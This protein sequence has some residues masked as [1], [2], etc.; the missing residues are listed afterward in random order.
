MKNLQLEYPYKGSNIT[1]YQDNFFRIN[2]IDSKLIYCDCGANNPVVSV[3]IPTYNAK[4][5]KDAIS[6]ALNQI[7]APLYEIVVVDN[8]SSNEYTD[9]L[10]EFV[11]K[12]KS[13]KIK[14]YQNPQNIGMTGNW[15]KCIELACTDYI[16]FLHSDDMLPPNALHDLWDFHLKIESN[17]CILGYRSVINSSGVEIEKSNVRKRFMGIKPAKAYKFNKYNLFH[18]DMDNG[19]GAL[20]NRDVLLKSGGFYEDYYPNIDGACILHYY[21]NAPIYRLNC[22]TRI[23]RFAVGESKKIGKIYPACGYFA[24][25]QIVDKFFGGNQFLKYLIKLNTESG[26]NNY[27][28]YSEMRKLRLYEKL[29]LNVDRVLYGIH[30]R[31]NI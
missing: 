13:E 19:C 5:L 6:S 8:N 24:R 7:E 14:I 29:I 10:L 9:E 23:A 28:G 21:L 11:K 25:N 2:N 15:N 20:F 26:K 17:A 12:A 22:K 4:F 16:V 27:C 1:Q 3:V 18:A 31:F 30:N